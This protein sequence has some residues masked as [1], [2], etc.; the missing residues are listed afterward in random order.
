MD[1]TTPAPGLSRRTLIK[2]AAWSIPV[3]AAATA[4]PLAA[5]SIGATTAA[6]VGGASQLLSLDVLT[7]GDTISAAVLPTAPTM[8]QVK[9]ATPGAVPNVTI[10]FDVVQTTRPVL[11]LGIG[12]TRVMRGFSPS[13]VTGTAAGTLSTTEEVFNPTIPLGT[14]YRTNTS[15]TFTLGTVNGG[16]TINLPVT[17]GATERKATGLALADISLAVDFSVTVTFLS[18]S[19]TFAQ[20]TTPPIQLLA[21][22][23]IL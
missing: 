1:E 20:L 16:Q 4:M 17:W 6:W 3:I 8:L 9:N 19:T 5:A 15:R 11:G 10:R 21:N 13:A 2:G 14:Y 18:G 22:A 23:G 12:S 7:P